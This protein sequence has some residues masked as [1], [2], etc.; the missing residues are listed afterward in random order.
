MQHNKTKL[1][2]FASSFREILFLKLGNTKSKEATQMVRDIPL[3]LIPKMQSPITSP[4]ALSKTT[5]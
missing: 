2:K 4:K 3:R 5:Q 1:Q